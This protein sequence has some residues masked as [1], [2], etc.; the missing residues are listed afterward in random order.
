MMRRCLAE[1]FRLLWIFSPRVIPAHA[2]DVSFQCSNPL[3][4]PHWFSQSNDAAH[5]AQSPVAFTDLSLCLSWNYHAS[6]CSSA[7]EGPQRASFDAQRTR[8]SRKSGLL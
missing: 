1:V 6:C 2:I 8:F 3:L 4:R 5:L 7:M